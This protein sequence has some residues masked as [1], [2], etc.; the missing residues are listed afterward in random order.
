MSNRSKQSSFYSRNQFE[1]DDSDEDMD[2][3]IARVGNDTTDE[4]R[5]AVAVD[6]SHQAVAKFITLNN[7][8]SDTEEEE[9]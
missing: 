9:Q 1:R 4:D 7:M 2:N 8:A 6:K 3:D 5:E